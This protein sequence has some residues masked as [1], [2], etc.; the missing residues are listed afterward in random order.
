MDFIRLF[1]PPYSIASVMP[2]V[3]MNS[4][5]ILLSSPQGRDVRITA[6]STEFRDIGELYCLSAGETSILPAVWLNQP[7][8]PAGFILDAVRVNV[9]NNGYEFS[10]YFSE[11]KRRD[12]HTAGFPLGV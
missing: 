12:R 4:V 6:C 3:L 8:Y 9:D 11:N 5:T 1:L 10:P 7:D 2:F